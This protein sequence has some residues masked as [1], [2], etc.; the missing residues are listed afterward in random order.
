MPQVSEEQ[1]LLISLSDIEAG[2]EHNCR[3]QI[4][5]SSVFSLAENIE[6]HGLQTPVSV[7][8]PDPSE[9]ID[10]PYVLV[11]G[12]RRYKAHLALA[13]DKIK[14]IVSDVDKNTAMYLNFNENV[15]RSQLTFYEEAMA[16]KK[17]GLAGFPRKYVAKQISQSDRYVQERIRLLAMPIEVQELVRDGILRQNDL[18]QLSRYKIKAEFDEAVAKVRKAAASGKRISVPKANKTKRDKATTCKSRKVEDIANAK[19]WIQAQGY[20]D[21]FFD[22]FIAWCLGHC[23][24]LSLMAALRKIIPSVEINMDGLPWMDQEEEESWIPGESKMD[25]Q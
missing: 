13:R 3:Y 2:D 7:R 20:S 22:T 19:K 18:E 16:I 25:T 24:D 17:M 11:S 10:K 23:H 4:S 9:G 8:V 1:I 15:Q 21:P 12:F 14:A 6:L 5:Q